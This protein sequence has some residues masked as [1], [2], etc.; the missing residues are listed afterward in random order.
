M[1]KRKK[2]LFI[3]CYWKKDT[4]N[5]RLF[6]ANGNG[7]RKFGFLGWQMINGNRR[8]LYQ[9]TCPFSHD[10]PAFYLFAPVKRNSKINAGKYFYN[11]V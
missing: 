6:A 1:I 9:H 2:L 11:C 8:L 4:A 3:S 7:R 5:F 10:Y